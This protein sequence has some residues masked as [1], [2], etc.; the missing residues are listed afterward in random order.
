MYR[1]FFILLLAASSILYGAGVDDA[2]TY[3]K[4]SDLQ[5]GVAKSVI[6]AID[7][8]GTEKILDV[9]CGDG[10]ITAYI[11]ENCSNSAVVGVDVSKSMIQFSSSQYNQVQHKNL[12]FFCADAAKLPFEQQFDVVV[13]FSTL[14]WVVNQEAALESIFRALVAGGRTYLLTY[15]QAPMNIVR[16]SEELIGTEKWASYFPNY[17][18][19]RVYFSEEE[20]ENLLLKAGLAEVVVDTEWSKTV[21]ADRT[22][23]SGF[24]SPLLNFTSHLSPDLKQQFLDDVVDKLISLSKPTENGSLVYETMLLHAHAVKP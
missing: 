6:T 14:H 22:A 1:Y 16:V 2:K 17:T 5:W 10:K 19:Q 9:G 23:L 20:Y 11:A 21:F 12:I 8:H 18:P 7:W 4:N 24:V 13:S 15:G 3:H